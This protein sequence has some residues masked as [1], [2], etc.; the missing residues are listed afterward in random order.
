LDDLLWPSFDLDCDDNRGARERRRYELTM[1]DLGLLTGQL[2]ANMNA[3]IAVPGAVDEREHWELYQAEDAIDPSKSIADTLRYYAPFLVAALGGECRGSIDVGWV[4]KLSSGFIFHVKNRFQRPRAYQTSVLL[5]EF[6]DFAYELALT[7][8]TPSF[9]SG[10]C[11]QALM[12]CAYLHDRLI[13]S[14]YEFRPTEEESLAQ[15]AAD[16]GDRRVFAGVHYPSDSMGSWLT[17]LWLAPHVFAEASGER[18]LGFLIDA[19]GRSTVYR[20]V[21]AHRGGLYDP[22]LEVLAALMRD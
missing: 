9:I 6:P 13:A 5:G 16:V 22:G 7:G 8:C 2:L 4:R 14:G 11:L 17:A 3:S 20:A 18:A 21:T 15:W 10:H 1:T 19:I 12:S